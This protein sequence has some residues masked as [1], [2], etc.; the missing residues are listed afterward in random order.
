MILT[1][2]QTLQVR[3]DWIEYDGGD[4]QMHRMVGTRTVLLNDH[5]VRPIDLLPL[6]TEHDHAEIEERF[7]PLSAELDR[8]AA[9]WAIEHGLHPTLMPGDPIATG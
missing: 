1:N 5:P 8:V 7:P 6:L 2:G 4:G 9:E 3:N